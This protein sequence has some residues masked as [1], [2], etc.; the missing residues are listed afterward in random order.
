M[1]RLAGAAVLL[2]LD[3]PGGPVDGGTRL[4]RTEAGDRVLLGL[5]DHVALNGIDRW[6]GGVHLQGPEAPWRRDEG[7]ETVTRR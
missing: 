6:V 1:A 2:E 3:L 7:T 4:R 5:A